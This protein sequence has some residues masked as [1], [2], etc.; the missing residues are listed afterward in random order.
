MQQRR[1]GLG[2][3]FYR[4]GKGRIFGERPSQIQMRFEQSNAFAGVYVNVESRGA[5]FVVVHGLNAKMRTV[6]AEGLQTF[7]HGGIKSAPDGACVVF[8][9]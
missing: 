5:S 8:S 2:D 6:V 3:G 7:K 1:A 4:G 9:M